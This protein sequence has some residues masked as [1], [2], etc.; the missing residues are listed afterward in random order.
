MSENSAFVTV[1]V[2]LVVLDTLMNG[3][4]FLA[5]SEI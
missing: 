3:S 1:I 5:C 2:N 4:Q